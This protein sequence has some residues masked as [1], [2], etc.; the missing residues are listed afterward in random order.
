MCYSECVG[1]NKK[2]EKLWG[3]VRKVLLEVDGRSVAQSYILK[4]KFQVNFVK[5][6]KF[7]VSS[8]SRRLESTNSVESTL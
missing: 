4:S 7:C 8:L 2:F 6:Q 3:V 1:K 5:S